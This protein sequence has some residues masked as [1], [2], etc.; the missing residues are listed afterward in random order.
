MTA[1]AAPIHHDIRLPSGRRHHYVS[2]GAKGPRIVLLHGF[3]DSWRS[4][5][6]LFP[7]L[8]AKFQLFAL[9]Q[10]G[11]GASEPAESYAIPDF[12]ADAI[13]FIESLGGAPVHLI[14]HSL[15]T[16]V[17]QRV[18][19]SRPDLLASL[20]LISAA[21]STG[22]HAGLKEMRADLAGFADRV[23]RDYATDFQAS[24]AH[25][26]LAPAQLA[27]FVDES[28]KLSL[29]AWRRTVDGLLNDAALSTPITLPALSIWGVRD[30]VFDAQAQKA[31][32]RKIPGLVAIHYEDIGHAPHWESPALVAKDIENFILSLPAKH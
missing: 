15:G 26:P 5:E 10:R 14:G 19:E 25:Q 20:I 12:V 32:A 29:D 13:S 18:A 9:D 4:F 21:P 3:T 28:M 17:A 8:S 22:G 7:A 11:H 31:L 6:L 1:S 24:T 16:I 30:G 27:I 2:V 23:P